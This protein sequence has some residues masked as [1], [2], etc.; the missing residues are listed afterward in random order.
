MA[1]IPRAGPPV[2]GVPPRPKFPESLRLHPRQSRLLSAVSQVITT[3]TTATLALPY[4]S[5]MVHLGETQTILAHRRVVLD[6]AY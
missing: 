6:A 2:A 1:S 4:L 5:A 3:K